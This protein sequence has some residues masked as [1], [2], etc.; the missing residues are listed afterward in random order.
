[1]THP[2]R[3]LPAAQS[4]RDAVAAM[5]PFRVDPVVAP[6]FRIGPGDPVATAGSCFAQHLSRH[7]ARTGFLPLVTEDGAHLDPA[8]RRAQQYGVFPARFGNI[9]TVRQLLQLFEEC[10]DGRRPAEVAWAR[11]DGRWV[12][13][14]RPRVQPEGHADEA[15][16]LADRVPHLDAVRRM[17]TGCAVFVFTLGLTEAWRSRIDGTVFPLAPGVAGG[18]FDPARHEFVNFDAAEVSA[19]LER[20]LGR[21]RAVNPRVNVLLTVSPVPLAATCEPRH[22]L[23]ASTYSKAVLRVAADGA[24]RRHDWVDYFPSFE[25]VTG[26]HTGGGYFG[27]D[28]RQ[29]EPLA[30]EHVMRVFAA[31]QSGASSPSAAP[32]VGDSDGGAAWADLVCDEDAIDAARRA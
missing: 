3:S 19:D 20:F 14:L 8:T 13:A 30:V 2:Y 5:E 11:E 22:V 27:I 32:A 9:Y 16:V 6:R 1:M 26:S 12:D 18:E 7:L 28:G 15:S 24:W 25:I 10:F 21:L 4:W 23:V 17:F 31:Y 29:V